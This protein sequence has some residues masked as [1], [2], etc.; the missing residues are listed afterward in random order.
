MF[1]SA[2]AID[3]QDLE[4][5]LLRRSVDLLVCETERC[6]DCGR[7]PLTGETLHRYSAA[8]PV[9]ELCRPLRRTEPDSSERVRNGEYGH[10]VTVQRLR[11][12]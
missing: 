2:P 9:C 7:T 12:A 11:P 8:V 5:A 4:R 6:A 1:R 3:E 10:A